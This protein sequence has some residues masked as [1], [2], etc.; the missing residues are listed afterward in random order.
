MSSFA[1]KA[2]TLDRFVLRVDHMEGGRMD[3]KPQRVRL[4]VKRGMA[5]DAGSYVE[6]KAMLDAPMQPLEPGSY[7]FVAF[8]P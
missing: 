4:S 8:A 7:D 3:E 6:V 1:K 2:S 5:P